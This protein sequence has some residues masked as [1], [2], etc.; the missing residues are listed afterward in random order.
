MTQLEGNDVLKTEVQSL[1]SLHLGL[2]VDE[3]REAT[4]LMRNPNSS[5]NSLTA[6]RLTIS[7]IL[8][9]FCSLEAFVN[10][11]GYH[12]FFYPES[13]D[14]IQEDKR[15]YLLSRQ[16]RL[17]NRITCIEKINLLILSYGSDPLDRDLELRISELNNLRNWIAHGM[18]YHTVSLVEQIATLP[19][20]QGYYIID[21]EISIKWKEKFPHCKFKEPHYLDDEDAKIAL[22]LIIE[23]FQLLSALSGHHFF[24]ETYYPSL[25]ING[26]SGYSSANIDSI[27]GIG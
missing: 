3:M 2:S 11:L 23:L 4:E 19:P 1:Y 9:S 22:R 6:R 7:S 24:F 21:Q 15:E 10:Y 16:L 12:R 8:H 27:L 25:S 18:T 26:V 14:Y 5:H 13:E 20:G 17:W